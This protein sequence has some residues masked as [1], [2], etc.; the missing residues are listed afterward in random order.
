M[1]AVRARF[2]VLSRH[3]AENDERAKNSLSAG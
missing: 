3:L 1:E 2:D